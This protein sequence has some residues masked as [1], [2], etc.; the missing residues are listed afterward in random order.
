ME[1]NTWIFCLAVFALL[2]PAACGDGAPA[3]DGGVACRLNSDCAAGESCLEGACVSQCEG[4]TCGCS[5]DDA[6]PRDQLCDG[7]QCVDIVCASARDCPLGQVCQRGQCEVDVDADRDRDGVPDGSVDELRDNCPE[8]PNTDQADHDGDGV[9]DVCDADDD[10]DGA[11]DSLDNCPLTPNNSQADANGD[12][13]GNACDPVVS[14]TTVVGRLDA[15]AGG[16]PDTADARVFLSGQRE[17]VGVDP[18]GRFVFDQ[19]LPDGGAFLVRVQWPGFLPLLYDDVAAPDEAERDVGV[20]VMVPEAQATETAAVMAGRVQLLDAD[21]HEDVRVQAMVGGVSVAAARTDA[22]GRFALQVSR[23]DH[24]LQLRRDGY[25]GQDLA[26]RWN[27]ADARFELDGEPLAERV[28]TLVPDRSAS[29]VGAL[30]SPVPNLSWATIAEDVQLIGQRGGAIQATLVDNRFEFRGVQ[31][32]LYGLQI[33]VEGHVPQSRVVSL[34]AGEIDLGTIAMQPEAADVESAVTLGGHARLSDAGGLDGIL[35]RLLLNGV[36]V[37]TTVTDEAGVYG[38]R[39]SRVSHQ[40]QFVRDGYASQTLDVT[41]NRDAEQFEVGGVAVGDYDAVVLERSSGQLSVRVAVGPTWLPA[42]QRHARVRV[43]GAAFEASSPLALDDVPVAFGPMPTDTYVVSVEREGFTTAQRVVVLRDAATTVE[44]NLQ[45]ELVDLGAAHLNLT[46]QTLTEVELDTLELR[47]ADLSGAR[48]RGVGGGAIDLCGR[49]L[50]GAS[51]VGADLAGVVLV[52]ADLA[53]ANLANVSLTGARL[54]GADLTGANFFGAD[55]ARVDLSGRPSGCAR[56]VA[57]RPT[58]LLG[59]DFSSAN[60]AGAVFVSDAQPLPAEPCAVNGAQPTLDL[61]GATFAQ[62]NLAGARMR[63]VGLSAVD[64]SSAL[65]A[66]TALD[67]ACFEGASLIQTNLREATLVGAVLRD[68]LLLNAILLQTDLSGADLTGANL[69]GANLTATNFEDADLSGTSMLGVI[70]GD[71]LVA[72]LEKPD[73]CTL[74]GDCVWEDVETSPS[75]RSLPRACTVTQTSFMRATL[76]GA[77]LVGVLFN[78]AMLVGADFGRSNLRGAEFTQCTFARGVLV[79]DNDSHVTFTGETAT[80][81]GADLRG[82]DLRGAILAGVVFSGA[83]LSRAQLVDAVLAA[84][85]FDVDAERGPT[86]LQAADLTSSYLDGALFTGADMTRANLDGTFTVYGMPSFVDANL[87][88]ATLRGSSLWDLSVKS[89]RG[90][91]GFDGASMSQTNMDGADIAGVSFRETTVEFGSMRDAYLWQVDFED[92]SLELVNLQRAI[93]RECNFVQTD[94]LDLRM[95]GAYILGSHFGYNGG[96]VD[97]RK[98]TFVGS[99][100]DAAT[101]FGGT[102]LLNEVDLSG[103]DL[104]HRDLSAIATLEGSKL[105]A[106]NF[107]ASDLSDTNMRETNM[108]DARLSGAN[109]SMVDLGRADLSGA[110][111]AGADLTNSNLLNA[112]TAGANLTLVTWS[113]TVCPDGTNSGDDPLLTCEDHL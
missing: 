50:S 38:F 99:I 84:T 3:D 35:V 113:N 19:G 11:P 107:E 36:P 37:D 77:E 32:G 31:P 100:W 27:G 58:R 92:A 109:L 79:L 106:T 112:S 82:A 110:D 61:T 7:G 74:P 52:G 94:L 59:A 69:S 2:V 111:L 97:F 80:F 34:E 101:T 46:G 45:I 21:S 108:R 88:Q 91:T 41:W 48:L 57:D 25:L 42:A 4:A 1:R 16:N 75:C 64:L 23:V 33:E 14:G 66:G 39:V 24:T 60:L 76:A 44:V 20:L 53:G 40:L 26:A 49:D 28:T 13:L 78:H 65:L 62:T 68:A 54:T 103:V 86:V 56:P 85:R 71:A 55:M 17:G 8:T 89:R 18:Q 105:Q 5:T 104:S 6:C 63:G 95:D 93:I 90:R 81:R 70:I 72:P 9:G 98:T 87:L 15:S 29:L 10:N 30:S 43:I 67:G 47:G 83:D 12:G 102:V 73:D 22:E 51:L 96:M